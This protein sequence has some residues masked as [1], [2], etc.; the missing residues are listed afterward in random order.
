MS[1]SRND[2]KLGF[3]PGLRQ[4]PCGDEWRFQIHAAVDHDASYPGKPMSLF[5]Y[6]AVRQPP[7][8]MKIMGDDAGSRQQIGWVRPSP[9]Q[10][11]VGINEEGGT[12][13]FVPAGGRLQAEIGVRA[14]QQAMVG[15]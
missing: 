5:Q 4:F 1:G 8:V 3:G 12:F 15:P 9:R 13:P 7:A 10:H 6:L 2:D 14:L 11:G